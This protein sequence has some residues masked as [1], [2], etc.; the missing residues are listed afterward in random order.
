M[1][2]AEQA[3]TGVAQ[4]DTARDDTARD[5]TARDAGDGRDAADGRPLRVVMMARRRLGQHGGVER[6]VSGITSE[7]RRQRPDWDVRAVH[8]FATTGFLEGLDGV[9]DLIAGVVLGWK[10][11]R[12]DADVVFVHCPECL[13]GAR[14]LARFGNRPP[15]VA[16]WHGVGERAYLKLRPAGDRLVRAL[17]RFRATEERFA[18]AAA[19]HVAVHPALV[20]DLAEEY[21][22]TGPVTV[23]DNAVD[24]D[25]LAR[26]SG[27]RPDRSGEPFTAVWVGQAAYRKGLDVALAAVARARAAGADVRLVVAGVPPQG[28]ADG[29]SWLGVRSPERIAAAYLDADVLLFP[30]R[31]ESFGLVVVEAMAAGLPVVVSGDLPSGI[32]TDGRNGAVVSGHDPASYAEAL[33]AL[34]ADREL[35]ARTGE[36][37][38]GDARRFSLATTAAGYAAVARR[39]ADG[40]QVAETGRAGTGQ[41]PAAAAAAAGS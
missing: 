6:V 40:E 19:A 13:W 8:A 4:D 1:P 41:A 32:V 3:D 36:V 20:E 22:F 10:V 23:V 27:A 37:N 5:D 31:Y 38:R 28:P 21:R 34:A 35:A 9:S 17:A 18:L 11:A 12:S 26:V 25:L 24:D 16:V 14:L 30:T 39:V 33:L 15:L 2:S 7:L 29:V